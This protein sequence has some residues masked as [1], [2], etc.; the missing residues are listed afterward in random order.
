M[1]CVAPFIRTLWRSFSCITIDRTWR[2]IALS[3]TISA[4][5]IFTIVWFWYECWAAR[6]VY[7]CVFVCVWYKI[8]ENEC[9]KIN[10]KF[11]YFLWELFNCFYVSTRN[12]KNIFCFY[13]HLSELLFSFSDKCIFQR[14]INELFPGKL[15]ALHCIAFDYIHFYPIYVTSCRRIAKLMAKKKKKVNKMKRRGRLYLRQTCCIHSILIRIWTW[16][17][18][19]SVYIWTRCCRR[20]SLMWCTLQNKKIKSKSE[21]LWNRHN[22]NKNK[23]K[24]ERNVFFFFFFS[25][26]NDMLRAQ[27]NADII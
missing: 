21:R 15:V 7:D 16:T 23:T 5:E 6:T 25:S 27:F 2:C 20:T 3:T 26:C 8:E 19:I 22:N 9:P 17:G 1:C 14:K 11:D 24:Q 4:S 13:F 18:S 12:V 10:I